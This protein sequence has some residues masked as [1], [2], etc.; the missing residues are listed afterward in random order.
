MKLTIM[1]VSR[2]EE[3]THT[4]S[5]VRGPVQGVRV[6]VIANSFIVPKLLL[7]PLHIKL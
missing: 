2:D 6:N 7:E 3:M 1:L 4:Y 5:C